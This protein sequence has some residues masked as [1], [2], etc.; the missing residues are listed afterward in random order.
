MARN[1]AGA[2]AEHGRSFRFLIRD[3]DVKFTSSFDAVFAAEGIRIIKMPV[4]APRAKGLASHCTSWAWLGCFSLGESSAAIWNEPR[5]AWRGRLEEMLVLVVGLVSAK[6][7]GTMPGL[8]R[9]RLHAELRGDLGESEHAGS[10]EAV[11]VAQ[12]VM[13]AA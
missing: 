7:A 3:R 12:E 9:V 8:D 6:E 2:L 10:S 4:R 1:L 13:V 11:P 5:I